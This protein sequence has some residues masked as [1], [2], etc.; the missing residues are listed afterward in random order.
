MYVFILTKCKTIHKNKNYSKIKTKKIK[1]KSS[2][3]KNRY[4]YNFINQVYN[5]KV[6]FEW[7]IKN[8]HFEE[9]KNLY[10]II[11]VIKKKIYHRNK[12]Q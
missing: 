6:I 4:F 7:I 11:D 12:I 1:W 2:T 3:K 10:Y 8:N 5:K 9:K